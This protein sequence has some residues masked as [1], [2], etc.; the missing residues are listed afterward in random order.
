MRNPPNFVIYICLVRYGR[1]D[2]FM[3]KADIH[4][5][6]AAFTKRRNAEHEARQWREYHGKGTAHAKQYGPYS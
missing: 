5:H 4:G 1:D 3:P 2:P 6:V